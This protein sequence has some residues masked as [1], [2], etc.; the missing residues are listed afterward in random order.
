ME[1]SYLILRLR[2]SYLVAILSHSSKNSSRSSATVVEAR[3]QPQPEA[4]PLPPPFLFFQKQGAAKTRPRIERGSA[5][6]LKLTYEGRCAQRG[7]SSLT[8]VCI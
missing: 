1:I 3:V 8:E 4:F 7:G 6:E 5:N 2:L